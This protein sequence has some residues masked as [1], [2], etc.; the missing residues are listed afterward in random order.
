M[1]ALHPRRLAPAVA[2]LLLASAGP[3]LA[4]EAAAPASASEGRD[5]NPPWM[6]TEKMVR[7]NK[8]DVN[9][10]RSGPGDSFAVTRLIQRD[11]EFLVLAKKNDW[12]NVR[13]SD[14]ETAWV[15]ESLCEE[16]DDLSG[17]EFRPNPRL[18]SRIGSFTL[19]GYAGGYS[20]DR[21]SNSLTAGGRLGYYV[22]DFVEVEGGVAW[23]HVNRP[24][25]VVENLFG[26]SIEAEQFHMLFYEMNTN[27]KLL[28]GRQLVPYLT[29]GVG[30]TIMRGETESTWNYGGGIQFFV[31]KKTAIRWEFRTYRFDSGDDQ[32]RR[33][34]NNYTFT[35]GTTLL[36]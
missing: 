13:L 31:K 18:F 4:Q 30:S 16:F 3:A 9:V 12:Y 2:L 33:T 22:F 8:A 19:T 29:T 36:L 15:H 32:A 21:K 24:A 17:L 14:S 28:P 27:L 5:P 35:V 7:F 1:I 34:N 11:S 25:E 6:L 26:L 10:V 20:F 23:S